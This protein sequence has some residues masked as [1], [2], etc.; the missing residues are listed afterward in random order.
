M[1]W[2]DIMFGIFIAIF[3]GII[4]CFI[5]RLKI[6]I[7]NTT[8]V[9]EYTD[10]NGNTGIAESC[11]NLYGNLQ[12]ELKRKIITVSEYTKLND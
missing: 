8:G 5:G 11:Y 12:C 1:D 7:E 3:I 10:L 9:F 4:I 6:K 2:E